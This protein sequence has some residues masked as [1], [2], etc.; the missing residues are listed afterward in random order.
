MMNAIGRL[1]SIAVLLYVVNYR[2]KKY[3]QP[4]DQPRHKF[5]TKFDQN[6]INSTYMKVKLFWWK[7]LFVC[8]RT[9][10]HFNEKLK[11]SILDNFFGISFFQ[12]DFYADRLIHEYKQYLFNHVSQEKDIFCEEQCCHFVKR[13]SL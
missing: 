12:F 9:L 1:R 11:I 10:M 3:I 6:F 4:M 2:A 5:W 13:M 8:L 7:L